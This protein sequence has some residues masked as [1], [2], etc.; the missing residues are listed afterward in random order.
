MFL[1]AGESSQAKRLKVDVESATESSEASPSPVM[2]SD[3]LATFFGTGEREMLQEEA[4]RR[5]WEYIKV[6]QLE[7]GIRCT[8]RAFLTWFQV[9]FSVMIIL[10]I[11]SFLYSLYFKSVKCLIVLHPLLSSLL[12]HKA[13][14]PCGEVIY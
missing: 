4:L 8:C 2:I 13:H 1:F 6:N 5:V 14:V 12:F 11:Y 7:V 10:S 9:S 3:A